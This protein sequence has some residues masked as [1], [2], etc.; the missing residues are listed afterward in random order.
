MNSYMKHL[1]KVTL[2]LIIFETK[3]IIEMKCISLRN[4]GLRH[5]VNL[6][7]RVESSPGVSEVCALR[8]MDEVSP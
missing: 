6:C 2:E 4:K 7:V 8:W 3:I 5:I 1:F